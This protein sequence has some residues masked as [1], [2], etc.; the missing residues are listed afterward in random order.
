MLPGKSIRNKSVSTMTAQTADAIQPANWRPKLLITATILIHLG[1][2]LFALAAPDQWPWA[3]VIVLM[4]HV[5]LAALGLTP[6][7]HWLGS[8]LVRLPA[9]AIARNEVALTLD[10]GPDPEVTPQVLD[11]LD[12]YGVK[13]T[14]FCIGRHAARYPELCREIIQRGHDIEN[15]TQHHRH[16]FSLL[17]HAGYLREIRAA[18]EAI[19][20][21]TGR[22]PRF[23]RAPAGF[24][25]IFLHK[26]LSSLQ[27]HLVSWSV[28]GFDTC[29]RDAARVRSKLLG[30]LRPGAILLMHDGNA[31][32]TPEHKPVVLDVLHAVLEAARE[33]DLHFV[34]LRQAFN[35]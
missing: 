3:I 13:A 16:T 7:N 9:D 22:T 24:R 11:I 27:L 31:A 23:F 19:R 26:A 14:F 35:N 2:A 20:Q 29:Q 1:A 17:S 28:R 5:F 18:Q 33:A 12:Q 34:T 32:R 10:D 15:H 21:I 6:G 8:N 25:N 4:N 30:G